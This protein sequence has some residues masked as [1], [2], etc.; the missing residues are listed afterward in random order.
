M[1]ESYQSEFELEAF[2]PLC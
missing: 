1:P 2:M